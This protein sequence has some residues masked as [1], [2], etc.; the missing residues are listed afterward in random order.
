MGTVGVVACHAA[1]VLLVSAL[2]VTVYGQLHLLHLLQ[3]FF[4]AGYEF[5]NK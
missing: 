2:S 3:A 1:A 4:S 5:I